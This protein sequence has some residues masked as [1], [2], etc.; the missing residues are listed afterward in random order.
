MKNLPI[1]LT[2]IISTLL[3]IAAAAP[4]AQTLTK[5]NKNITKLHFYVHNLDGGPKL[6]NNTVFLVANASITAT[7]PTRFG[8]VDVFDDLVTA[9]PDIRSEQVAR[10]QGTAAYAGLQSF[11]I[12]LNAHFYITSGEF[13]RSTL[14]VAA[15]ITVMDRS[16]EV[17]VIGGTGAFR[18]ARGYCLS[19]IYSSDFATGYSI[20]EYTIYVVTHSHEIVWTGA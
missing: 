13:N 8:H 5:G 12:A 19:S 9:A 3:S 14:G 10:V 6:P 2:L 15:H 16:R 7:S 4:W 18:L 1:A 20:L 11:A 17:P